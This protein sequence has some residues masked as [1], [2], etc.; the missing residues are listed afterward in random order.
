[1]YLA[2]ETSVIFLVDTKLQTV[3]VR[4]EAGSHLFRARDPCRAPM[5]PR[6]RD[7]GLHAVRPPVAP[8]FRQPL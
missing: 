4:D 1:V 8:R 5:P 3:T 2:C 7:A 6:L